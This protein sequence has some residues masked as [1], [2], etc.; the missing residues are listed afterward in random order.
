MLLTYEDKVGCAVH[1]LLQLL[2]AVY[3]CPVLLAVAPPAVCGGSA[4]LQV[5]LA[6]RPQAQWPCCHRER[7]LAA[8]CRLRL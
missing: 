3:K 1:H 7:A 2:L 4:A 6:G 5:H 8:Q